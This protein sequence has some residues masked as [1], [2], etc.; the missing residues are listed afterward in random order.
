[1]SDIYRF[2][3]VYIHKISKYL[4]ARTD[5]VVPVDNNDEIVYVKGEKTMSEKVVEESKRQSLETEDQ[6]AL[7]AQIFKAGRVSSESSDKATFHTRSVKTRT[8]ARIDERRRLIR[9]LVNSAYGI[10][11]MLADEHFDMNTSENITEPSECRNVGSGLY[12]GSESSQETKANAYDFVSKL[13]EITTNFGVNVDEMEVGLPSGTSD[14]G[15][16][17]ERD[18]V[19]LIDCRTSLVNGTGIK[20]RRTN[21]T[22]I[23]LLED[24]AT[25]EDTDPNV[26]SVIPITEERSIS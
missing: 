3:S 18:L 9:N 15:G 6:L 1:M 22:V 11:N 5:V 14:S 4:S 17:G 7:H 10:A 24:E 13:A 25:Q 12:V 2:K 16:G 23:D 19:D 26:S 8:E 21:S 20:H